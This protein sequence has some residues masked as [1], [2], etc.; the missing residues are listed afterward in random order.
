MAVL[1]L[2]DINGANPH[3][4][5]TDR[6]TNRAETVIFWVTTPMKMDVFS[7]RDING[8]NHWENA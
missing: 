5:V 1:A 3:R 6:G 2:Q 4:N 7:L 8:A